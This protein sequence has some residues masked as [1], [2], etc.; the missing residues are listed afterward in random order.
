M[1]VRNILEFCLG[2]LEKK[3]Q[4]LYIIT[5]CFAYFF[6]FAKATSTCY[7]C[8]SVQFEVLFRIKWRCPTFQ[9]LRIFN[10]IHFVSMKRFKATNEIFNYLNANCFRISSMLSRNNTHEI[11]LP[12]MIFLVLFISTIQII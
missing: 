1:K 12:P 2:Q 8:C 7:Y 11:L 3:T 6:F 5:F 10:T 4:H 9:L